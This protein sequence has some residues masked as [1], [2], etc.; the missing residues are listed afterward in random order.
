[1]LFRSAIT[2]LK[3]AWLPTAPFLQ[4]PLVQ[5]LKPG[6]PVEVQPSQVLVEKSPLVTKFA[7]ADALA[8]SISAA[9]IALFNF[10]KASR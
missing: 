10:I 7:L 4:N 9:Q 5:P 6:L 1:M 2:W 3:N 8:A